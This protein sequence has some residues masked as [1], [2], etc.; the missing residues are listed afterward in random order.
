MLTNRLDATIIGP[1]PQL[2]LHVCFTVERN[3]TVKFWMQPTHRSCT[4]KNESSYEGL[5]RIEA[6]RAVRLITALHSNVC[7]LLAQRIPANTVGCLEEYSTWISHGKQEEDVI[8][9]GDPHWPF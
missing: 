1:R 3:W 4:E 2:V 9:C 6:Y 7:T 5:S 8:Y